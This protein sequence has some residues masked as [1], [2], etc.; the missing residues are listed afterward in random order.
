MG[1]QQRRHTGPSV[2]AFPGTGGHWLA[3]SGVWAF[4]AP[5][6][7]AKAERVVNIASYLWVWVVHECGG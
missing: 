1:W 6:E 3:D 7:R 5:L 4:G 2:C